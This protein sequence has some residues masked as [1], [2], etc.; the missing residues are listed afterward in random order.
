MAVAADARRRSNRSRRPVRRPGDRRTPTGP[1]PGAGRPL[2]P[3]ARPATEASASAR[4]PAIRTGPARSRA[5]RRRRFR[6]ATRRP[7]GRAPRVAAR[8]RPTRPP[9]NPLRLGR[10]SPVR[11]PH[12]PRARCRRPATPARATAADLPCSPRTQG[13]ARSPRGSSRRRLSAAA[14]SSAARRWTA[15]GPP[16]SLAAAR[17][18]GGPL[19]TRPD[20]GRGPACGT[21]GSFSARGRGVS[22]R[23]SRSRSGCRCVPAIRGR[24]RS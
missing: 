8:R 10:G 21:A 17:D 19:V 1:T 4:S 16:R 22:G 9:G 20:S 13:R 18:G 24:S 5:R 23:A 12:R 6:L 7:A 15:A 2:G 3:T 11:Y 14:R